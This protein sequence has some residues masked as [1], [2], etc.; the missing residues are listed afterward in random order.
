MPR[1]KP[2]MPAGQIIGAVSSASFEAISSISSKG[3]W[4]SRSILL[5]KVM[6]GTSRKRQTS[7]SFSVCA[8]MPLAASITMIA[9]SA[10]VSVR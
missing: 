3:F 1:S 9:L 8:S 4:P 7:K 2:P 10:A 5:M 6:I